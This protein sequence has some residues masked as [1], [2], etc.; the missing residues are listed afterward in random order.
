MH[1]SDSN[2]GMPSFFLQRTEVGVLGV[3]RPGHS[4]RADDGWLGC[5]W[6]RG[7]MLGGV[8]SGSS[9]RLSPPEMGARVP[10]PFYDVGP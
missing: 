8:G 7:T 2:V 5:Y 3:R 4:Q 1:N 6:C 9:P 10:A